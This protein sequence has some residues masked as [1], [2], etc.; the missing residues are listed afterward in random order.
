MELPKQIKEFL[1]EPYTL[2]NEQIE[3]YQQNRYI[4]LKQVL[5]LETLEF[6]NNAIT[7]QVNKMNTVETAIEKRSTYG[8]AFLQLF[9]FGGK[10]MWP[11]NSFLVN[12][13]QKLPP[14]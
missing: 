2:S 10:A 7:A 14:T 3:F 6:F 8:K 5:N 13:W 1:Q 11:K 4:K 12:A 9:N